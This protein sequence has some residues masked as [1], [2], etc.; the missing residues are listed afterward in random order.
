MKQQTNNSELER[1]TPITLIAALTT[2]KVIGNRGTLPWNIPDDLK[3]F[4]RHTDGAVVI[5]GRTT[6]ES[7]RSALG[8]PLPNRIN[9]VVSS[10]LK[11][12]QGI[13][14]CPSLTEAIQLGTRTNKEV[15]VIG[16]AQLYATALPFADRLILSWIHASYSGDTFFPDVPFNEWNVEEVTEYPAFTNTIYRRRADNSRARESLTRPMMS[17]TNHQASV[18]Y[19]S[20]FAQDPLV[21]RAIES[22]EERQRTTIALIPS[23][24]CVSRAV[25]E[26][27]GTA[28]MNK[29]SEGYP[30]KRYYQGNEHIDTIENAAIER[31]KQLFGAEHANVQPYSGSP[32]NQAVYLAFL[33][34]GETVLG[35]DLACGGHLTHGSPVN[36]SGKTYRVVTYTVDKE[37]H[38]IDMDAVRVIALREKPRLIISGLTAYPRTIDFER[39]GAIA[40]EV[41]AIHLADISHIS[42]LVATG[43]HPSPVPHA[44]VV[45]TTTHKTLRGPR[46]A[47]LLCKREHAQAIDKA[48]FPGLQGGPHDNVTAGKAVALAEA[49]RPEFLTYTQAV[50]AN[51]Q[52]MARTLLQ[53]GVPLVTGGTDN[54]LLLLDLTSR[55]IGRGKEF[56]VALETAGLVANANSIPY[57]PSTPFK[58]SGLRIGSP[59]FTSRGMGV[60]EA[61]LIA[62]WIA[63]V[64]EN[65]ADKTRLSDIRASVA[66]LCE[67]FPHP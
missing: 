61:E 51:A 43:L 6:F 54:H 1:K 14:V 31:A 42:G 45:M 9:I 10:T 67:Q 64:I 19:P 50:L 20:L 39:F 29:Y 2:D 35:L 11:P 47:I 36:F 27:V 3:L 40:K 52:A 24:N 56:A 46:G 30:G 37:T 44:D 48:V 58:P 7:I 25:R 59:Y 5:M 17:S 8:H 34:P 16:G 49:L 15:Y 26:A 63:D 23:E 53:R 57:D 41:G 22:E 4:K 18:N 60:A 65:P 21:A 12:E 66:A 33:K 28:L 32:A 55:G 13:T 62:G 38:R